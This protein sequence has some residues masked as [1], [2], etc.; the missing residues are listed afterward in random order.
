MT[1]TAG[2]TRSDSWRARVGG[3]GSSLSSVGAVG[4]ERILK[5]RAGKRP[6]VGRSLGLRRKGGA[7]NKNALGI[8]KGIS[9]K[10]GEERNRKVLFLARKSLV[11]GLRLWIHTLLHT[12]KTLVDVLAPTPLTDENMLLD[13]ISV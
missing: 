13:A 9:L 12:P 7:P 3:G 8:S 11:L 10:P 5:G 2:A 1:A 4:A 6:A